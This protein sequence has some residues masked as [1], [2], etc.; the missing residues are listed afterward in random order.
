MRKLLT[1][2]VL[3]FALGACRAGARVGPV[4][5][6]GGVNSSAQVIK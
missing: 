2:A 4:H 5:A 6:G 3:T 1:L